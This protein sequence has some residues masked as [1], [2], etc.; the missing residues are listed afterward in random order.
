MTTQTAF[1]TVLAWLRH[2]PLSQVV[3]CAVVSRACVIGWAVAATHLAR[4]YDTGTWND[5]PPFSGA[6]LNAAAQL[7]Y[8]LT[9]WDG[10]YF[11]TIA[12]R[13]YAYEQHFAFFPLWPAAI[14]GACR[15][16]H[17]AGQL[18]GRV[19]AGQPF[20]LDPSCAVVTSTLINARLFVVSATLLYYL[21]L[22]A[23]G[24]AGLSPPRAQRTALLTSLLF[25]VNPAGPFFSA[26]YTE[27]SFA[28]A[29]FAAMLLLERA[30]GESGEVH[31]PR[32]HSLGLAVRYAQ[33]LM[34]AV[35][36]AAA[37]GM[38]SNGAL[39]SAW[40]VYA[41]ARLWA[42]STDV[43][44][45]GS[46]PSLALSWAHKARLTALWLVHWV[47]V[48]ACA[49]SVLLPLAAFQAA[50]WDALCNAGASCDQEGA[51]PVHHRASTTA[52]PAIQSAENWRKFACAATSALSFL[53]PVPNAGVSGG[54]STQH[55]SSPV[56]DDSLASGRAARPWCNARTLGPVLPFP[57]LYSF[58]QREYW[59][60]GGPFSYWQV[61]NAPQ[62]LI[63]APVLLLCVWAVQL[64]ITR[65]RR[66]AGASGV[67]H[68]RSTVR[69]LLSSPHGVYAASLVRTLLPPLLLSDPPAK[70]AVGA[71][72]K[73]DE[74]G[75]PLLLSPRALPYLLHWALLC[76][77]GVVS[78]YV[79][80]TVR[81]TAAACPALYWAAAEAWMR[82]EDA[83]DG[84]EAGSS[85]AQGGEGDAVRTT[86]DLDSL[87]PPAQQSGASHTTTGSAEEGVT[88]RRRGVQTT[89]HVDGRQPVQSPSA[90]AEPRTPPWLP[91]HVDFRS[92][93]L[94]L[95]LT[96][97]FL[98][99]ALFSLH[100][101]WT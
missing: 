27:S 78:M 67:A 86:T 57:P 28:C 2:R 75:D 93:W 21:T 18:A 94:G 39:L 81:V 91:Y 60:V 29:S 26:A 73:A 36:C 15:A 71:Q 47:F 61:K 79:Q 59:G 95:C 53:L 22:G 49:V 9:N 32:R 6:P 14:R 4:P 68:G 63:A 50:G 76:T 74:V 51:S 38:R 48:S 31:A 80:V 7:L 34:G 83:A 100:Y 101:N 24:G 52:L 64:L 45:R 13:G 72:G 43:G 77:L 42:K 35:L 23:A 40:V 88:R 30:G 82:A 99:T 44:E 65:L 33:L 37:A 5:A 66:G 70:K 84:Q 41:G 96:Y 58:V 19:P 56:M 89:T 11:M 62:F 8:P 12:G 85:E 69:A 3:T 16:A 97:T 25:C 17:W 87:S 98:G 90:E 92:A 10:H 20:A 1:H 46:S 55:S 54:G